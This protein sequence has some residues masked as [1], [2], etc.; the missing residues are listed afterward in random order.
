MFQQI[1]EQFVQQ[2]TDCWT[3]CSTVCSTIQLF[4]VVQQT[5]C[6]TVC[7]TNRLFK[8]IV[9]Q[10]DCWTISRLQQNYW[11]IS[12]LRNCCNNFWLLQQSLVQQPVCC[13]TLEQTNKPFVGLLQQSWTV[14]STICWTNR[15]LQQKLLN[16]PVVNKPIV[17]QFRIVATKIVGG[18]INVYA[19]MMT[20]S[21]NYERWGS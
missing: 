6:S 11:T 17:Q 15:M 9:Q 16:K 5:G 14:C 13:N 7:S 4:N 19:T 20:K 18:G 10:S 2:T 21:G 12:L 1:V 3:N 8:Q